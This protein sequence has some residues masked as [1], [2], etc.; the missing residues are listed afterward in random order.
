MIKGTGL[1]RVRHGVSPPI[2]LDRDVAFLNI[3]IGRAIFPHGAELDE[4]TLGLKL[5]Q[6]K[7]QIERPHDIVHLSENRMFAVDHG[8]R[9]GALLSKMDHGMRFEAMDD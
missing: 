5:A 6:R 9:S 7:E 4:V 8:I 2:V 1:L 3:D